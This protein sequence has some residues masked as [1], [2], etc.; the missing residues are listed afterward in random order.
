[1]KKLFS[2]TVVLLLAALPLFAQKAEIFSNTAGAIRG[3]DPVA[4]FIES[5]AVKGDT[6]LSFIWKGSNWYFSTK[7]NLELF[8]AAPEKYAPQYGGYCAYG[9]ADGHKA[10]TDPNAWTI[11]DGKLYFNYNKQVLVMWNKKQKEFIEKADSN[12]PKIK[13]TE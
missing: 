9:T 8:K 2:F 4:Y 13:D 11:V 1:M 7:E 3:Y 12:W 6:S 5:K 10:P